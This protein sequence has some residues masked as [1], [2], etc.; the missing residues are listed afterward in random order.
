MLG[1]ILIAIYL[2]VDCVVEVGR[3]E[4]QADDGNEDGAVGDVIAAEHRQK[5]V[6]LVN[7]QPT[8]E[9]AVGDRHQA[10]H[11]K[12]VRSNEKAVPA[13][14]QSLA[15]AIPSFNDSPDAVVVNLP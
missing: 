8:C 10:T 6:V 5:D 15:I 7:A 3:R 9:Q 13:E 12:G 2:E 1:N 11:L 14:V 4:G